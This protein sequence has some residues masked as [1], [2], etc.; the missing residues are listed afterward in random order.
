MKLLPYIP[1][2]KVKEFDIV[3]L[4]GTSAISVLIKD[5]KPKKHT[6]M[7]TKSPWSHVAIAVRTKI[8]LMWEEALKEGMVLSELG[9]YCSESSMKIHKFDGAVLMRWHRYGRFLGFDEFG[10]GNMRKRATQL[11]GK[12]YDFLGLGVGFPIM[13]W[14]KLKKLFVKTPGRFVCSSL[15]AEIYRAGGITLVEGRPVRAT[16]PEDLFQSP[17]LEVV[18]QLS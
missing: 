4:S 1:A 7:F 9:K 6:K 15:V 2:E 10:R 12:K 18:D 8:G 5:D 13:I 11:I 17:L 3:F 16:S 14:F